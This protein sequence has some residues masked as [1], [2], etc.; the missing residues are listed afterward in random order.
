MDTTAIRSKIK[1][2]EAQPEHDQSGM[3]RLLV[4]IPV[5]LQTGLAELSAETGVKSRS[6]AR[7]SES[8]G[9][10][11][12]RPSRPTPGPARSRTPRPKR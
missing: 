8:C 5:D 11:D 12:R 1:A 9:R 10:T 7:P 4:A 2:G 6:S 3:T